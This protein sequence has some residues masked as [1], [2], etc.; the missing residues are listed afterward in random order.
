MSDLRRRNAGGLPWECYG[1][2]MDTAGG[3]NK[4]NAELRLERIIIY[5]KMKIAGNRSVQ[6]IKRVQLWRH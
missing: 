5:L 1:Y 6:K 3:K 4:E 2:C